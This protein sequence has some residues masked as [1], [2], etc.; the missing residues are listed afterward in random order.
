MAFMIAIGLGVTATIRTGN[1]LGKG[2][3][4]ELVRIV[5]SILLLVFI[6][7]LF[8]ALFFIGTHNFLPKIYI[9]EPAV[10]TIASQLLIIVAWFQLSDGF[11]VTLLGVLRGLQDVNIPTLII[12]I[13]YWGIG[14]PVCYTLGQ[15]NRLG[16]YG[17]WIGLL[18]GLFAS[19]AMLFARYRYLIWKK[20]R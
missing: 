7:E 13:A 8:L 1:Q 10:I 11:Q 5:R 9:D 12:L 19:S 16:A 2:N 15:G 20:L 18:I 17:I 4:K 14:F 3:F 6:L